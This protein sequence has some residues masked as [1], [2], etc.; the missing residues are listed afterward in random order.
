M[1]ESTFQHEN[2]TCDVDVFCRGDDLVVRFYHKSNEQ[3]DE[4]IHDLVVV[5]PGLGFICLK[6]KGDEGLLSGCLDHV[7]FSEAAVL[8][9]IDFVQALSPR[10]ANAYIPYR[11]RLFEASGFIEYNGE[12]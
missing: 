6:F 9:A 4:E 8:K 5:D 10:S 11:V 1:N 7:V 2:F 3:E 12:Y